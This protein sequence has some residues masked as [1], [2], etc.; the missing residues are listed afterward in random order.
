MKALAAPGRSLANGH[1]PWS[2]DSGQLLH[3]AEKLAHDDAERAWTEVPDLVTATHLRALGG[4]PWSHHK[5]HALGAL[6]VPCATV[7][8]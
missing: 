3:W 4:V 2:L 6:R 1:P 5:N 8:P 7:G